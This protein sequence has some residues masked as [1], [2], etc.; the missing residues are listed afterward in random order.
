MMT[1]AKLL[2]EFQAED[3]TVSSDLSTIKGK[4]SVL[5]V[6]VFPKGLQL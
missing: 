6:S 4:S 5:F 1:L 2:F 3:T